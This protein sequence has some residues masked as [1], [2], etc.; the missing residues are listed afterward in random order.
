VVDDDHAIAQ[1]LGLFH[2]MRRVDERLAPASKRLQIVEDGVAALRVHADSRFV[3][4]QDIGVVHQSARDV[5][6][7]LHAAA[8]G[9]R[10]VLGTVGEADQFERLDA[11]LAQRVPRQ[12]VE[13]AEQFQIRPRR[14]LVVERKVLRHQSDA[15]LDFAFVAG[16]RLA[17]DGNAAAVR[18]N[19]TAQHGDDRRLARAVGPQQADDFAGR[20]G[21]R[22]AR[23]DLARAVGLPQVLR[24]QHC[25][26]SL[27]VPA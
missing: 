19:E 26:V 9:P 16:D 5:E 24:Y 27:K 4:Q 11:A 23:D 25:R 7:A 14:Q 21:E 15:A 8:E 18:R 20:R 17:F 1:T 2:V 10:L 12:A 22:N 6:A 3:E 13:R